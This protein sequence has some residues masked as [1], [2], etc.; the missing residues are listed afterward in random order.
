MKNPL[1]KRIPRELAAEWKKY[2]SLFLLMMLTIGFV[3]GMFVAND[4]MELAAAEA[5]EKYDIEDGHFTLAE[6]AADSLVTC[7]HHLRGGGFPLNSP[8]GLSINGLS[9]CAPR[10]FFCAMRTVSASLRS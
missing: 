4:S 5:F 8:N 1:R 10:F 9:P 3:A 2:L 6:E 7:S